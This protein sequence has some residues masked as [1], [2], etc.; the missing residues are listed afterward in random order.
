MRELV[1]VSGNP[2]TATATLLLACYG[3]PQVH[4]CSLLLTAHIF[5]HFPRN[6]ALLDLNQRLLRQQRLNVATRAGG[7]CSNT[8]DRWLPA[9]NWQLPDY[10]LNRRSLLALFLSLP[11]TPPLLSLPAPDYFLSRLLRVTSHSSPSSPSSKLSALAPSR[12]R[13]CQSVSPLKVCVSSHLYHF[14][15]LETSG[16]QKCSCPKPQRPLALPLSRLLSAPAFHVPRG[17]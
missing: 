12:H 16:G 13:A 4:R 3:R 17:A 14:P 15:L 6:A 5:R 10:L 8:G 7:R 2:S 11:L 9:C 1:A